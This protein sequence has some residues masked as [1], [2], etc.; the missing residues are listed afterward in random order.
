METIP[1]PRTQ[2]AA[3][4]LRTDILFLTED[5]ILA[6]DLGEALMSFGLPMRRRASTSADLRAIVVD[7]DGL[8]R[9][10]TVQVRRHG[11]NQVPVVLIADD[12]AL[13]RSLGLRLG[14]LFA[15]P[16]HSDD[17]ARCVNGLVSTHAAAAR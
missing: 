7:A 6:A 1:D 4:P 2:D 16:V 10:S 9:R 17:V 3:S 12:G 14:A 11:R 15:K 8:S 5:P 13:A